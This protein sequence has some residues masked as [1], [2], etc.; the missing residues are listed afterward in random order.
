MRENDVTTG[1]GPWHPTAPG[2]YPISLQL[3]YK[4]TSK[5]VPVHGTGQTRMMS[6]KGITFAPGIRLVPG[7]NAEIVLDWPCRRDDWIHLELVLKVSITSNQDGVIEAQI[8]VSAFR[9][10]PSGE[11][12]EQIASKS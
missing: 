1:Q 11:P 7:M 4:A 2:R 8:V 3:R 12:P 10:C 6:S 9:T 5:L